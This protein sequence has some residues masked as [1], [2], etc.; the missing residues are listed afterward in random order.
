MN[1]GNGFLLLEIPFHQWNFVFSTEPPPPAPSLTHPAPS[2]TAWILYTKWESSIEHLQIHCFGQYLHNAAV[3]PDTNSYRIATGFVGFVFARASIL[4][5]W[6]GNWIVSVI[7]GMTL[8]NL[9]DW[10]RNDNLLSGEGF[11]I[12]HNEI[13]IAILDRGLFIQQPKGSL[14]SRLSVLLTYRLQWISLQIC[15]VKRTA[16]PT[17]TT[18][19]NHF[20]KYQFKS[21]ITYFL[22]IST[23]S[24]IDSLLILHHHMQRDKTQR[25]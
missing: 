2:P 18:I 16:S 9:I 8:M 24:F 13:R 14:I 25:K 19:Q 17:T 3:A 6:I 1:S 23:N 15:T 22:R 20:D 10:G 12:S 5:L 21:I 11:S 4:Q 7:D